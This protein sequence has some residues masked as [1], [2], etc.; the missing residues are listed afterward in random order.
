M[1]AEGNWEQP[2]HSP[3]CCFPLHVAPGTET[4]A[5]SS[6]SKPWHHQHCRNW[7]SG[8]GNCPSHS[9]H[10]SDHGFGT[11]VWGDWRTLCFKQDVTPSDPFVPHPAA[12]TLSPLPSPAL[13]CL[14]GAGEGLGS[15]PPF[16]RR[17][18]CLGLCSEDA[19]PSTTGP[20]GC[21]TLLQAG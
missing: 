12:R 11:T 6:F 7:G 21:L 10:L 3:G 16:P 2:Q 20:A 1:Q 14:F 18:E 8:Q 17:E 15:V 5:R 4:A 19:L 13:C 9:S